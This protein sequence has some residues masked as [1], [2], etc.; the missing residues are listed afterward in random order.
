MHFTGTKSSPYILLLLKYKKCSA[1]MDAVLNK[2][3]LSVTYYSHSILHLCKL[4]WAQ[5]KNASLRLR[6]T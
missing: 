2:E 5:N 1:R 6:K 4:T 3:H